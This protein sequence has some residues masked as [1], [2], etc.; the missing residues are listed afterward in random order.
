MQYYKLLQAAVLFKIPFTIP[1]YEEK[2]LYL[3]PFT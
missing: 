3:S 2:H 1:F